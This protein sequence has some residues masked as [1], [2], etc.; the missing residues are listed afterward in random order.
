MNDLFGVSMD[1]IAV[2][3][4]AVTAA[5]LL[6]V[7]YIAWRNPVMFKLGLRNIPR[8]KAQSTLIVVGLMLSTLIMSAA[9]GTGD[10]LTTSVTGEVYSIL[11][12][13][14]EWISWDAEKEPRPI[15]DQVI[16]LA[17][18]E[19]WQQRFAND[20]EI[21]AFVPFQRETLPIVNQ[22]TR[23]NEP[24]ARIVA[25]RSS[26]AQALGGLRDL[27][28]APVALG[29]NDIAINK[30]LAK[31][32]GAQAGDTVVVFY[33]GEQVTFT[34]VAIVPSNVLGGAI[35][36]NAKNG[37]AVDFATMAAI[38]GRGENA[39]AVIV[40]NRG[41]VKEGLKHADAVVDKLE[42][43]LEDTPYQVVPL[44]KELVRFAEL[45]GASFTAI[46]VVFGLFSIAAGVLLIFLIFVMLA[47]ER[48]PEMGMA[49]AVGAKRRQ[50]VE[51][52]LAEG[53]GYDLGAAVV[54]LFAGMGVTIAMV[55][56]IKAFAA[57]SLGI[58]LNV[59]FT[60]RS[61][62][63]AFCLGVIATFIVIFVSSWRAS[64]LNITA[65][66][67]DLPESRP[68]DPEA[69]TWRGYYRAVVNGLAALSAPIGLSFFLFGTAG[70]V[71]GLPLVLAGLISPWF[72]MLRGSSFAAP[73]DHRIPEPLPRW[74]WILGLVIPVIGW[75][76]ILPWYFVA[77]LL[78][79]LTR[80]RKPDA[81]P[82]WARTLPLVVWPSAFVLALLQAWRV[83]IA[84]TAAVAA[85][86]GAAGIGL[87]YGG[88][89]R[90]SAF[91]FLL[92]VSLIFLW[93]AVT[94]HYFGV[95]ERVS[96]TTTSAA[97]LAL[98]YIPSSWTEPLFGELNGDIEMFFVS[99][100]V[101]VT[102]GVF[103]VIYNA[104]IV[105][106]AIARLGS[107]FGR[108]VPALKTGV[109]YPLTSRFRTGM[110]MA[111]IG[112]IM[113]S[114]V[115]M[116]T[117]NR[118]FAALFLNEDSKGGY[119]IVVAVNENNRLDG[120]REGLEAAGVDTSPIV[121]TGELRMAFAFEAEVEN[122]DGFKNSEDGEVKPYSR[123]KL[124]G[125]DA[126]F[127]ESSD[128]KLK[129]RAAGYATDA[130]V[131]RALAADPALAVLPASTTAEQQ[132][133]GQGPSELLRLNPLNDGFEPFTL[134]LRDPGTGLTREITVIAQMKESA[135]TFLALGSTDF[136]SGMI[137]Q[138]E[139]LLEVF[140]ASRGQRFYLSVAPG[141][142][143]EEYAR[144]V[145]AALVQASA[146]SLQALLDEQQK[147]QTG[148]LL[149]FQGFMGLGLIVGIAA[150]AVIASRA[151]VERRQQI[152]MLRAI[153]YQRSMVALSF[154]FESGFIA[155]SGILLGL[156]LGLSLAW[157]LFTSGDFGEEA[158]NIEFT[159][160][161]LDLL[162][163]SGIALGA[164]MLMTFLPARSAS[165]VPVAEALRYE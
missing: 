85:G 93:V 95:A 89:D 27:V 142:D 28:G 15:E 92:G 124:F 115:M 125:A 11:G 102:C 55:E 4:M 107:R 50:L 64:R 2:V 114:L 25:F 78:L 146:D 38:T 135:E 22:R 51:S 44:K 20:P 91:F 47:A 154:L 33:G 49:R 111:M 147:L 83:R 144:T 156:T 6:F 105:L 116:A 67:R 81:L 69:E 88:L 162:V 73:A 134:E 127:L 152:G 106:P 70:M 132:G 21:E 9:F 34:V 94:L 101:M 109:A 157:V 26:D 163:I 54:G 45:I 117:I 151:V 98:W 103:I 56:I 32:I 165:R 149:V 46:F 61:L 123:T 161:W 131:W 52:F 19:E 65:A 59:T 66:I 136:A 13:A 63:V 139:T 42:P 128:V 36:S 82:K 150:L 48:K 112:L 71:L 7:A 90:D 72:Y 40:S 159:V 140:P 29:G 121:A 5:I 110:T 143:A 68:I 87:I 138:K 108:I 35:D 58:P 133:F 99:G 3:S 17:T 76:L 39:N 37:A 97:L 16:P 155:L 10:T 12:E 126:A 23:L 60:A 77:V 160:P 96:F 153:G 53:M 57:D 113:F 104:D 31:E 164:A 24:S 1:I 129:F 130:E 79:R 62:A 148:F 141:T 100:M 74:P 30:D 137:I 8:R 119:D 145:E 14:D 120:I 80:D 84:W 18:V 118:N 86:F 43:L 41:G 122:R 158:R 75:F